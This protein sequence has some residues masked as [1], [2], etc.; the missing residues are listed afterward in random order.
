LVGRTSTDTLTNKSISGSTNTLSNIPYTASDG[1]FGW[2][3]FGRTTLGSA[4]ST[5]AISSIPS[6]N[7]IMIK[8]AFSPDS[9]TMRAG[10]RVNGASTTSDYSFR[11]ALNYGSDTTATSESSIQVSVAS[12]DVTAA[13]SFSGEC[14]QRQAAEKVFFIVSTAEGSAGATGLPGLRI[15]N[16][17]WVNTSN[18]ISSLTL[19][20]RSGTATNFATGSFIEVWIK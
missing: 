1:T 16:G 15:T 13:Q 8:G 14:I 12:S 2:R 10:L 20:I 5:I 19:M 11:Y 4:A 17:K 6:A 7:N 3:F 18:L 9:G